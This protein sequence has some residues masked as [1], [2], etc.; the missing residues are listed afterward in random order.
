METELKEKISLSIERIENKGNKIFFFVQDTRGNAKAS[1]VYL[2][3]MAY[4]LHKDG[5]TVVMLHEKPDYTKIGEWS[6]LKY[7]ELTHQSI[8]GTNLEVTPEDIMVVPE[9]FGFIMEQIKNLPCGKIVITQ[10]YDHVLETLTP[11]T[12]WPQ[13]GFYK[14]ITT[15]ETQKN[16][17]EK[18]MKRVTVDVISPVIS[19]KFEK[20]K[21][22][23]K[24]IIAVHTRDQR[25]GINL[26]K[27]F[28]LKYPQYRFFTFRDLRGVSMD[29]FANAIQDAFLGVW[30]DPTSGFGTFPLECMKVG[31]PVLGLKPNLKPEWLEDKNG[32]WVDNQIMMVDIIADLIQTW[33][34]DN[35][36]K[37]L[38]VEA[39]NTAEKYTNK[40]KFESEVLEIFSD[41]SN[42]RKEAFVAQLNPETV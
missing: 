1:L 27:Q 25:D 5:Y 12:S 31:I 7:D 14:C 38:Y 11:G 28:Y 41:F 15:S 17:I 40:E 42:K 4:T 13:L 6:D 32:I 20:Q 18:L 9:I 36:L 23:A 2:Y 35:L 19:D 34:E 37:E 33:L 3:D 22:P 10:A 21:Y 8:E 16:Q 29:E 24:P 30:I 26:I 39:S